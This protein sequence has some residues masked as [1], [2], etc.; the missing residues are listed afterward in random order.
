[1][2][3]T[4]QQPP[5]S[6]HPAA[7][8]GAAILYHGF[9]NNFP[10]PRLPTL[11]I[12]IHLPDIPVPASST[13]RAYPILLLTWH[14]PEHAAETPLTPPLPP[15]LPA[16][17]HEHTDADSGA[18]AA[19][20]PR[21]ARAPP[22]GPDGLLAKLGTRNSARLAAKDDGRFVDA[23]AKATQLKALQNSLA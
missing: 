1:M 23:T 13:C 6:L 9:I 7:F 14:D 17:L 20:A 18:G 5:P 10:I 15:T 4:P 19:P 8:I 16:L 11:P 12:L 3:P 2:P 21:R 22:G